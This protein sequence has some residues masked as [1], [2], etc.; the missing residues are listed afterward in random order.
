MKT[1]PPS[2]RYRQEVGVIRCRR[3]GAGTACRNHR[4]PAARQAQASFY[5]AHGLRH[6]VA[7]SC[8]KVQL[9]ATSA[10]TI[11][12]IGIPAIP[13]GIN[14]RSKGRHSSTAST[15]AGDEKAVERHGAARPARPRGDEDL[16]VFAGP[17]HKHEAQQPLPLDIAGLKPARIRERTDDADSDQTQRPRRADL[18][19]FDEPCAS[20]AAS[21]ARAG[22]PVPTVVPIDVQPQRDEFGRAYAPANADAVRAR[23]I[24]PGSA[25]RRQRPRS[26]VY[27]ARPVLRMLINQ[28]FVRQPAGSV[29]CLV[30]RSRAA[31]VGSSRLLCAW[32]QP[33]VTYYE[34]GCDRAEQQ[35]F[36]DARQPRRRAQR[37]TASTRRGNAAILEALKPQAY[38]RRAEQRG[39][40]IPHH[41]RKR[42][43]GW[44][45]AS[46]GFPPTVLPRGEISAL[47]PAPSSGRRIMRR[48]TCNRSRSAAGRRRSRTPSCSSTAPR[49]VEEFPER[50]ATVMLRSFD[51]N[52][53]W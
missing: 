6:N 2:V 9:T 4:D 21:A 36:S 34:P 3:P 26:P 5:A 39:C 7:S 20:A 25:D 15:R 49:A 51:S 35:G 13:G 27:F 23:G 8:E 52:R 50:Y 16:R 31:A 1:F 43:R 28:P 46:P 10:K 12:S 17:E 24:K 38:R 45:P 53:N 32:H 18:P 29:R 37:N 47:D 14:G 22:A 41:G 42:N 11:S 19:G 30:H 44:P 48:G 40:A 33:G